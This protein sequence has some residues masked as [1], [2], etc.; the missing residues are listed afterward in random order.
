MKR[1]AF[2]ADYLLLYAATV[3]YEGI[4]HDDNSRVLRI[5]I[6]SV[7]L[8]SVIMVIGCFG[9]LLYGVKAHFH[10]SGFG[11]LPS[12][13][14]WNFMRQGYQCPEEAFAKS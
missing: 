2:V 14:H 1:R 12:D 9:S 13:F 10:Y 4:I 8:R 7:L 11:V 5:L 3:S 6:V